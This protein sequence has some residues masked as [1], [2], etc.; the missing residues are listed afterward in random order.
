MIKKLLLPLFSVLM[1]CSCKKGNDFPQTATVTKGSK[2]GLTIGSSSEDVY[3][4]LQKLG[5]EK[6]FSH[7]AVVGRQPFSTPGDVEDL[8]AFYDAITLETNSGVIDRVIMEFL[9]DTINYISA[10]GGLTAETAQWPQDAPDEAAFHKGDPVGG[11]YQ[12]LVDIYKMPAYSN[13]QIVLPDKPLGKPFDPDMARY[14]QWGFSM[15]GKVSSQVEGIYSVR[16]FF[17]NGKLARIWY[18]YNEYNV[19]Q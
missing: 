2:W 5:I 9:R 6:D 7:V 1:F 15:S 10:G 12:K 8:L 16:L 4:Q 17:T 18:E 19:V 11:I 3:T 14:E 13:Y